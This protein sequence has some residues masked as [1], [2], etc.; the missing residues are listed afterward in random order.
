MRIV[1]TMLIGAAV[2]GTAAV[3]GTAPAAAQNYPWCAD[4]GDIGDGGSNCGFV[5]FAQCQATISGIGGSCRRNPF[6]DREPRAEGRDS[7]RYDR[8]DQRRN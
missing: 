6:Y 1:G 4:Y 8:R 3:A 2:L 5:S 7:R